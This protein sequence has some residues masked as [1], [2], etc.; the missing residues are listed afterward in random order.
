MLVQ[1][2]KEANGL[3]RLAEAHL[4]GQDAVEAVLKQGLEAAGRR[5]G[6]VVAGLGKD[7]SGHGP[8][9]SAHANDAP[10]SRRR[11]PAGTRASSRR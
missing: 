1:V 6:A 5:G 9:L 3:H 7:D 8:R 10:S 11:R 2:S 4:V